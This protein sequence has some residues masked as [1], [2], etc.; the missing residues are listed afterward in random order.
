MKIL[1]LYYTYI[2]HLNLRKMT[3][4]HLTILKFNEVMP[5]HVRSTR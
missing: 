1:K 3:K 2:R 4:F 5:Y